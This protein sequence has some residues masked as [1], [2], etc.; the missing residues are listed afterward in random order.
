MAEDHLVIPDIA[1]SGLNRPVLQSVYDYW[2]KKRGGRFAPSRSDIKP[3]EIKPL[4]PHIVILDVVGDLPRF[5]YRLVGTSF[6]V[7]YGAEITGKFVDE[8]DLSDQRA[9]ILADY[10]L[11]VS[12]RAPSFSRWTYTKAD[13]RHIDY[14]RVLLPLS[15]DGCVVNMLFGGFTATGL[16]AYSVVDHPPSLGAK[17]LA[18]RQAS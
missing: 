4:L 10:A 5:R 7:E 13:G 1:G 6:A 15:A 16:G 18:L 8:I 12:M 11:V 2:T 3:E 9:A 14:S 17:R